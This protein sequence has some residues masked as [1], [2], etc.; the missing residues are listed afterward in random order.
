VTIHSTDQKQR[1]TADDD[2]RR[3]AKKPYVKPQV[4]HERVFETMALSCGKV[5]TTEHSCHFN[6]KTS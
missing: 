4:R 1:L 3:A 6:R 5:Q 2:S